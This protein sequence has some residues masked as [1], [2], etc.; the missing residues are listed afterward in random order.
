M[1]TRTADYGFHLWLAHLCQT[2]HYVHDYKH[3][4]DR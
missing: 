3:T 1:T 4:E 2:K